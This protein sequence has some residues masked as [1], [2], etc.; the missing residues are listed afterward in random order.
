MDAMDYRERGVFLD[1]Q[2]PSG[3]QE[4]MATREIRVFQGR[5]APRVAK[6]ILALQECT[7][8]KD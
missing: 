8:P 6:A 4:K 7:D 1:H 3:H 5:K 2:V